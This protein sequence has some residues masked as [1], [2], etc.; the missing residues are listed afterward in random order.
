MG[1][2][3]STD[4]LNESQLNELDRD[5][6][7]FLRDNGRASPTYLKRELG[8]EKS[9]QYISSRMTRLAEHG[10]IEDR[11]DTGIYDY[12]TWPEPADDSEK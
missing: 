12:V 5:I 8:I 6:L 9:R 1:T 7:S 3:S 2:A 11:H 10:Y 4:M